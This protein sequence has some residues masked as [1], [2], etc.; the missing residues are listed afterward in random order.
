LTAVVL[1]IVC[2][3]VANPLLVRGAS[4]VRAIA[5]RF[6]LGATRAHVV[7]TLMLENAILA[8]AGALAGVALMA[9]SHAVLV[10]TAIPTTIPVNLEMRVDVRV[11]TFTVVLMSVTVLMFGVLPALAT[12]AANHGRSWRTHSQFRVSIDTVKIRLHRARDRLRKE[13]GGGCDFYRNDWNEFACEPKP[14]GV[15]ANRWTSVYTSEN[16]RSVM[17]FDSRTTELNSVR[18]PQIVNRAWNTTPRRPRNPASIHRRLRRPLKIGRAVR[19]GVA[20]RIDQVAGGSPRIRG[21][22][23]RSPKSLPRRRERAPSADWGARAVDRRARV[24]L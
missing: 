20:A 19:K 5:I 10:G 6:A 16:R 12:R 18:S 13:L 15:S 11:L 7:R 21:R 3:N 4:R 23:L 9:A 2:S 8:I 17:K 22:E 14:A 1:L 24:G